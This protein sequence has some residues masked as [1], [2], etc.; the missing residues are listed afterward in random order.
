M[1]RK[2][3]HVLKKLLDILRDPISGLPLML[4]S[5]EEG[6]NGEVL[7][8]AL[9]SADGKSY[10][11]SNGIPRFVLTEDLGQLQTRDTFS[12]KWRQR[13]SWGSD[14]NKIEYASWLAEKY[15]FSSTDEWSQAWT[16]KEWILDLGCGGGAGSINWLESKSWTGEAAWVGVDIS[17][18]IDVAR[19][20]LSNIPGCHFVQA[21]A[22]QLPFAENSFDVIFSEGVLHHTPSTQRALQS[23]AR[24]LK[25][26]GELCFYVYR[27]KGPVR[28][29]TDDYIREK[30]T[31]LSDEQAWEAM[32][33]LTGLAKALSDLKVDVNVPEDI[34]LLEIKAGVVDV[35]RLI[36]WNFAK[37]FWNDKYSFEENVHV[38]FDWYRP[39]YAH[40]QSAEAIREWCT[41]LNLSIHWF[42]EQE[43]G[44]TVKATKG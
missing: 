20:Y 17:E 42:H 28:E 13:D 18:A 27:L 3:N 16:G 36:Y 24:M 31:S 19:E 6:P 15:G 1:G 2:G 41:E 7:K 9:R 44:Y 11:I 25:Q 8:G 43:S 23:A 10:L 12:F 14:R 40:R 39:R 33:S 35:Q 29:F 34:P 37:L 30:I 38:N 21:D 5:A 4:E 22:L 26:G 32:R